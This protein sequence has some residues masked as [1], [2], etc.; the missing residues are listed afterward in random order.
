MV[1]NICSD[2]SL[3][4]AAKTHYIAW[5][6]GTEVLRCLAITELCTERRPEDLSMT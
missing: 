6:F 3:L 4:N 2:E 1:W 5:T